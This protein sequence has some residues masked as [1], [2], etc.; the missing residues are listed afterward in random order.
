MSTAEIL[1][2]T[3]NLIE[4]LRSAPKNGHDNEA[5]ISQLIAICEEFKQSSKNG[6]KY[7]VPES[8]YFKHILDQI[9][10]GVMIID[11]ET[12]TIE[13]INET[14]LKLV[15][16]KKDEVV[17]K[18]C[19]HLV[20]P[21][22]AGKCP[23]K[24]LG[25]KI[26]RAEKVILCGKKRRIPIL[27]TVNEFELNGKKKLIETFVDITE[28]AE[29][30]EKISNSE[31][32]L[33]EIFEGINDAAYLF[34]GMGKFLKVNKTGYERLGYTH[35]EI[36]N[37]GPKDIDGTYDPAQIKQI[38]RQTLKDGG[39]TFE[40]EHI[41]K[42]GERIPVEISSRLLTI[43]GKKA[44]LAIVRD[45]SERKIHEKR[46]LES[47]ARFRE[48]FES[49]TNGVAIYKAWGKGED[50]IFTDLNT[51]GE[52]IENVK[53]ED[54]IGKRLSH[55]FPKAKECGLMEVF[56][57]VWKTGKPA[58]IPKT[59]Y[60]D[61]RISGWRENRVHR[62]PSGEIVS[63]FE[64]V[65]E[66]VEL[67]NN[68]LKLTTAIEQSPIS[69]VI[70]NLKGEIEYVNPHF[71]TLTGYSQ[72][73]AKDKNP[74]ILKTGNL[75]QEVYK[76]LWD[77]IL[78]G[79]N[80]KGE[81]FN[82]KKNGETFW[83]KATIGPIRNIKGE[84]THFI[85][86][87]EDITNQKQSEKNL[88]IAQNENAQFLDT[89]ADGLRILD[90][91]G[92]ILKVNNK[93]LE[94]S[95]HTAEEVVGKKCHDITV[96]ED[97]NTCNCSITRIKNG[98]ALIE[99]DAIFKLRNGTEFYAISRSKPFFDVDGN[100]VGVI[101]NLKDISDR[102]KAKNELKSQLEFVSTLLDTIPSPVFYKNANGIYTGCN[103]AFEKFLN[104]PKDKII[105]KSVYD[106]QPKEI[107]SKYE[108]K[109]KE[110]INNPGKQKYEWTVKTKK[111]TNNV[112]FDKATFKNTEG[113]VD[114]LI[115]VITDISDIKKTEDRLRR[116]RE[117]YKMLINN[118]GEG[119]GITDLDE[120]FVFSNILA[121]K[122][123]GVEKEGLK[124]RSILDFIDQK[125]SKKISKETSK[126]SAGEISRYEIEINRPDGEV[127][128]ILVTATPH[129]D[130]KGVV[131]GTLGIFRDITERIQQEEEIRI[132]ELKYRSIIDNMQD[133]YYRSDMHGNL[134]MVSPS[135]MK[136]LGYDTMED[137]LGRNI[138]KDMFL[139]PTESTKF[140]KTLRQ[141]R[142]VTN[143]EM[144]LKTKKGDPV[145]VLT[146]SSYYYDKKNRFVGVE[147]ILTDI[148]SRKE[149]EKKLK[150]SKIDSDNANKAKSEFLANMSHEI[151]TPMNAILGFT[152]S[153][154]N[155]VEDAGQKKMLKS[156]MSSGN[157]LLS[158]INDILDLSKIEAGRLE[159]S[160]QP[161]DLVHIMEE[162]R[163]LF[164]QKLSQKGLA[165]NLQVQD[166]F[167]ESLKLDEIRIKQIV[168]NLVGNAVKFT[169]KGYIAIELEFIKTSENKGVLKIHIK[170]T[171]MGIP[172]SQ[173]KQ[174]FEAFRQQTGQVDRH[175]H[176]VGLGL[177]I[178]TKLVTKM[179]G[180]IDLE[181]K[182]GVGSTFSVILNDIMITDLKPKIGDDSE[183]KTN[184]LFK[185][186]KVL[187]VDDV[188]SNIDVIYSYLESS[189]LTMF[190]AESGELA[191]EI[192]NHNKP[193]IILTDIRM[194]GMGGF[195]STKKI[196]ENILTKSIPVIAYTASVLS[197]DELI[198]SNLFA[199][200][201]FKPVSKRELFT[202][203]VKHLEYTTIQEKNEQQK[204]DLA[205]SENLNPEIKAKLPQ[206]VTILEQE[207]IP[208]WDEIKNKLM[209]FKID[210][211]AS[212]L[213]NLST[214]FKIKF[215]EI[216][217]NKL[218]SEIKSMDLDGMNET[219][220][221]FPE[222]ITK[223]KSFC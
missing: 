48:L 158:L 172:A 52:N 33:S 153:L 199:G 206:L 125:N 144:V 212:N 7:K 116:S 79:K 39:N 103:K 76:N 49:M 151:R 192:L 22:D 108:E 38:T 148:T 207:Y 161:T 20:C 18:V 220:Q 176:G 157:L 85:A 198:N 92:T 95:G 13:D 185:P 130:D 114:G 189:G 62:L 146:S 15:G 72:D 118:I 167:P 122:I 23:I 134:I 197:S 175:H 140:I 2:S 131:S 119:I 152:E 3:G 165:I 104:M 90:N 12:N 78:S 160:P 88:Q 63:V 194:P 83:E 155:K 136:L 70:T 71:T 74:R 27:K 202:E 181:S 80:W 183:F 56:S 211:F 102:I 31:K 191:I 190:S 107:A 99:R 36:L 29:V 96:D 54:I 57:E 149:Y 187:V 223:I 61:G 138:I 53:R 68:Q 135:G 97:C 145:V 8:N 101:Q 91:S 55:I 154:F 133:V 44:V 203:L 82:K 109:D 147:G 106:L 113:K 67:E 162:I 47:E 219:L 46:I 66:K 200:V 105:G 111:D 41:T 123:F 42:H 58:I 214:Q 30:R 17:G 45:I 84:I 166:D 195:E 73:E 40:S 128:T 159:I 129:K 98:E 34:S 210:E 163:V 180:H 142:S 86:V 110:L 94:M 112:I 4:L 182:P 60:D 173:H 137:L 222:V 124:G 21:A 59:F 186:A 26:D 208:V 89:A 213:I 156:V 43:N 143:Y 28:L 196:K 24:D 201:L 141:Q 35:E 126:R 6:G 184:I 100:Q 164:N 25:K 51:A 218:K 14:G 87:K 77:T 81:F 11:Y 168:F 75:S 16:S 9:Q 174:I 217:S 221:M 1:S 204:T 193:D 37:L 117:N 120:N 139:R 132:S 170:D 209:L 216:Y 32:E 205:E 19:H 171:G 69:V 115:G 64:D 93:F 150:K 169:H 50:F 215:L 177:A 5:L 179:N 121:D 10:A 127:R 178:T 65:T 188:Q